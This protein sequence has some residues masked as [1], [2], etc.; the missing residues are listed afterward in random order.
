MAV[1]VVLMEWSHCRLG[2]LAE[3]LKVCR[4]YYSGLS[5]ELLLMVVFDAFVFD[6]RDWRQNH[7]C[8]Q[9][10]ADESVESESQIVFAAQQESQP[11]LSFYIPY[12]VDHAHLTDEV[13]VCV[14][15]RSV[16]NRP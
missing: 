12:R 1:V 15:F 14:P 8:D 2:S 7:V 10:P 9:N 13:V 5:D 16:L 3:S 4:G 11:D 6:P